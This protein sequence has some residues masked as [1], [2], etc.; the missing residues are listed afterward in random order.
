MCGV[1][2]V[3]GL[4]P[5]LH[6]VPVSPMLFCSLLYCL[7]FLLSCVWWDDAMR[8]GEGGVCYGWWVCDVVGLCP[9]LLFSSLFVF[10][11]TALLV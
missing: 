9:A 5:P 8:D 4:G 10:S 1:L 6:V 2:P 7:V 11:V 3:F